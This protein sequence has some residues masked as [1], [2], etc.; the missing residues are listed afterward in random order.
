MVDSLRL[1]FPFLLLLFCRS[2]KHET[3]VL[4][5]EASVKADMGSGVKIQVEV[6]MQV[7]VLSKKALHFGQHHG[8]AITHKATSDLSGPGGLA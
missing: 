5:V 2:S 4:T 3:N 1:L 7:A 6:K 8:L